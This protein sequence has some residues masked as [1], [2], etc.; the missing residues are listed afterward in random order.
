[1]MPP[2]KS[3][4]ESP[5]GQPHRF[6]LSSEGAE[7]RLALLVLVAAGLLAYAPLIPKLGFYRDDWYQLWAGLTLG[8]HSIITLFSIDRPAM[9]YLYALTFYLFGDH[10]LYWQIYALLLRLIG[11]MAGFW[12][13]RRL[14]PRAPLATL[15]ASL[16]LLLY[17]GFQQQPNANTFSN[18]LFSYAAA[19]ISL[20]AT[21]EMLH[22]SKPWARAAYGILSVA[23]AL[24]YWLTYEYMIGLEAVRF[25][26]LLTAAWKPSETLR[27]RLGYFAASAAPF[28]LAVAGFLIWRLLLFHSGR[29]G[30]SVGAVL[31]YY[32]AS[33]LQALANRAIS[34][35]VDVIE[36]AV[37]GWSVPAYRLF[38]SAPIGVTLLSALIGLL[39]AG[40]VWLYWR[41][42]G[43][44]IHPVSAGTGPV[45]ADYRSMAVLG[46]L[47]LVMS[48]VPVVLAGRDVRW[49]S[50]F[51]RYTLQATL[52]VG[53]LIVG[54][55]FWS[56]PRPAIQVL[57]VGCLVGAA[58][59]THIANAWDWASFWGQERQ[60]FWQLSWRA[61]QIQ[62]GTTLM[63]GLPDFR[64]FEDYEIW[65]P[66]NLIYR[67]GNGNPPI[68][69]QVV[70]E[71]TA[72][73]LRQGIKDVR[74][75]RVLI[76]IPRDYSRTLILSWPSE[77]SCLH[78]LD[79]DQPEL[80]QGTSSLYRSIAPLSRTD[81][82][83][84]ASAFPALPPDI[85]GGEPEHDWCWTYQQASLARQEGNWSRITELAA[86]AELSHQAPNDPSEWMPIFQ[87]YVNL[88]DIED[89]QRIA[90]RIAQDQQIQHD[91]CASLTAKYFVNPLAEQAGRRLLCPGG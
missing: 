20:A 3:A 21:A 6:S 59:A 54:V 4:S 18:H 77:T 65:G 36:T 17:P 82:I 1:M 85:Y 52:G 33:P 88:G 38:S 57:I 71:T 46:V 45:G 86:T 91:L 37:T 39:A 56:V 47:A 89:A 5:H 58:S 62:D 80:A 60:L 69:A 26:V 32:R 68:A 42:A 23:T 55:V 72:N 67:N 14:W 66:A 8:P 9:G 30:V 16:L 19:L 11:A 28:A 83:T 35:L 31:D 70:D 75:M 44:A 43:H 2:M 64:F 15:S 40:A 49:E 79:G 76:A 34:L 51:D 7:A 53:L 24:A 48:L 27:K 29:Q 84:T 63:T 41:L 61:P 22:S 13:M 78:V 12:F 81:L 25:A 50:A 90:S 74:Y 10:P 73:E 87:A